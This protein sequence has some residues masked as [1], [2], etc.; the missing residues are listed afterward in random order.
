VVDITTGQLGM[1]FIVKDHEGFVIVAR[2]WTK[3][4]SRTSCGRDIDGFLCNRIQQ[5]SV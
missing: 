3:W 5:R 1:S 2:S 4:E